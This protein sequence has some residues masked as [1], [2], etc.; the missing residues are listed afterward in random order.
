MLRRFYDIHDQRKTNMEHIT[1]DDLVKCQ[2]LKITF[3]ESKKCV[4][5]EKTWAIGLGGKVKS[6]VG[7]EVVVGQIKEFGTERSPI[8][9]S[10]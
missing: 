2:I 4:V 1:Y 9:V 10:G 8:R 5:A 6:F 7:A 3:V